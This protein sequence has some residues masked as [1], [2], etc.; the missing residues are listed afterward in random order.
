MRYAAGVIMQRLRLIKP[1]IL[2]RDFL[3]SA[4]FSLLENC[5]S[6][7]A[8]DKIDERGTYSAK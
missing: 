8:Y 1:S 5:K 6:H 2:N 3:A 7:N 4:V